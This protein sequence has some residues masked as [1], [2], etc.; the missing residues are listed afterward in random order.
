MTRHPPP[1]MT[2]S[3]IM[4]WRIAGL[5]LLAGLLLVLMCVSLAMGTRPLS[6]HEVWQAIWTSPDSF[7]GVIIWH[8]RMPRALLAVAVG[9]ALGMAGAL[10]QALTRNQLADPGLLG[11]HA[12]AALAVVIAMS[13]FGVTQYH[14]Y[15]LFAL[16]G[17]ALASVAVYWLGGTALRGTSQVRLLLAGTAIAACLSSATGMITLLDIRTFDAWRFW[18]VGGLGGRDIGILWSSLP[19]IVTGIVLGLSQASALDSLALGDELGTSLGLNVLRVRVVCFIAIILLCGAATAAVGPLAFVGLVV[20]HVVRLFVGPHWRWILPYGLLGG[21]VIVLAADI[22]GRVIARPDEIE[23][24]IVMA[25]I[26]APVLLLKIAT[27]A[28]S[29]S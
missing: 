1:T 23:A 9:C 19:L 12:G 11:V 20:P 15:T 3:K 18:M 21:P 28:R 4:A 5:L 16:A 2:R 6:L 24:G 14:G 13:V 26:G 25:L 7:N 29:R 8:Y 22:L 27:S 10:M 17:A